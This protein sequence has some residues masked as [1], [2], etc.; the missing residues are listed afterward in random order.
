LDYDC[1]LAQIGATGFYL[2]LPDFSETSAITVA[3]R[4]D[5]ENDPGK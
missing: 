3:E 1:K 4:Q 2:I 5:A